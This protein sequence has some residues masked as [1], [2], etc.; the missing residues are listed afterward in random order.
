[1]TKGNSRLRQQC[2]KLCK[3]VVGVLSLAPCYVRKKQV[4]VVDQTTHPPKCHSFVGLDRQIGSSPPAN[5]VKFHE[6]FYICSDVTHTH[7]SFTRTNR[8]HTLSHTILSHTHNSFTHTTLHTRTHTHNSSTQ[9]F[10][11]HTAGVALGGLR[12]HPRVAGVALGDIDVTS[13]WD[14]ACVWQAWHSR[15][16]AGPGGA[17]GR[18]GHCGTLCCSRGIRWP[19]RPFWILFGRGDMWW[20]RRWHSRHWAGSGGTLGRPGRRG[21]LCGRRDIRWHVRPYCVAGGIW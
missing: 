19:V 6:K 18:P 20:Y 21:T 7:G 16:W 4:Q 15:H 1:M 9:N 13:A 14:S 8:S 3:S 12:P 11:T 17:L 10:V 2:S 5:R